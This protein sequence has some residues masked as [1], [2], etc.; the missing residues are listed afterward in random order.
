MKTLSFTGLFAL[1]FTLLLT[2]DPG[3]KAAG[4]APSAAPDEIGTAR[5]ILR[6]SP[7]NHGSLVLSRNSKSIYIDPVG[8]LTR[9]K[10]FPAPALI[11]ITHPHGDHMSADTL[12]G[13]RARGGE[14]KIIAPAEVAAKLKSAGLPAG[15]ILILK[16]GESTNQVGIKIQALAMYNMRKPLFHKK[17][18]WN[19]YVLDFSGTRVY[20]SGD[21]QDIPEMRNLKNIDLAFV[22]MN[23]PYTM[24]AEKAA[25]AVLAFEPRVVYPYHYRGQGENGT[26]DPEK[27]KKLVE[28][29]SKKIEV[30]LRD[31]YK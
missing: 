31:W 22:C 2:C 11:L 20:I 1:A 29:G 7:V 9:Y 26:Q 4:A 19:G 25:E 27:F 16:N 3:D 30:R 10:K 28:A 14:A 15:R 6:I 24:T 12:K 18:D 21:T 17:G 5:G 13:L 23:L 8:P